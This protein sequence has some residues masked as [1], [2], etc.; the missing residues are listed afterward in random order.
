[1]NILYFDDFGCIVVKNKMYFCGG[2]VE[3][4]NLFICKM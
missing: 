1:M 2:V 4:I 3:R